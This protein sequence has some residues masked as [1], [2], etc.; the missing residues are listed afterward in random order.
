MRPTRR[1][2]LLVLAGGAAVRPVPALAHGTPILL[3]DIVPGAGSSSLDDFARKGTTLFFQADAGAGEGLWKTDGTGPGT[4]FVKD[5]SAG[6]DQY[7]DET[8][9]AGGL[10]CFVGSNAT[11]GTEL[12]KS[13]GT[14]A[15]TKLVED[16]N[17]GGS[18][19]PAEL[20]SFLGALLFR[21]DDG[22][23][24][25]ELWRSDGTSGGTT[26]VKDIRPGVSPSSPASLTR[27]GSRC[28]SRRATARTARSCGGSTA[29]RPGRGSSR[30]SGRA[31][32]RRGRPS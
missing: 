21:A 8:T 5:V 24:G 11:T 26:Q 12:W 25:S 22:T 10:V 32:R 9:V 1:P 20:T 6:A 27:V 18:A 14:T 2:S 23:D 17:P 28:S 15:G 30:T 7:P 13:D 3:A 4:T 31:P 19:N 29:P 16:I